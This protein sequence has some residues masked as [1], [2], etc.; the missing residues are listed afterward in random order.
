M[1]LRRLQTSRSWCADLDQLRGRAYESINHKLGPNKRCEK[2]RRSAPRDKKAGPSGAGRMKAAAEKK[3]SF[4]FLDDSIGG[5]ATSFFFTNFPEHWSESMLWENFKLLEGL[6]EKFHL[7]ANVAKYGRRAS[8]KKVVAAAPRRLLKSV[9]VVEGPSSSVYSDE[10]AGRADLV[11]PK[12]AKLPPELPSKETSEENSIQVVT[13]LDSKE[14]MNRVLLGEV[15]SFDL[16]RNIHEFKKAEGIA[17]V[18]LRYIGGLYIMI[19]FNSPFATKEYLLRSKACWSSWFKCLHPWS[20]DFHVGKRLASLSVIGLPP[21]AWCSGVISKVAMI[22]GE[23]FVQVVVDNHKFKVMVVENMAESENLV[24]WVNYVDRHSE[25]DAMS[26]MEE[27][28]DSLCGENFEDL[29]VG[30]GEFPARS[31]VH[32]NGPPKRLPSDPVKPSSCDKDDSYLE[33]QDAPSDFEGIFILDGKDIE[34]VE[35]SACFWEK[36]DNRNRKE[37]RDLKMKKLHSPCKCRRKVKRNSEGCKH[38][39]LAGD[40]KTGTFIGSRMEDRSSD[41]EQMIKRRGRYDSTSSSLIL[42]QKIIE[43]MEVTNQVGAAIGFELDDFNDQETK[44][45]RIIEFDANALWGTNQKGWIAS[46]SVGISGRLLSVWDTE[47][48]EI[49]S[50]EATRYL[51]ITLGTWK[52]NKQEI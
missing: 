18:T 11:I 34:D 15:L 25:K 44:S 45:N 37:R 43:E 42:R 51:L 4:P 1:T 2:T 28:D 13:S 39:H 47:A 7:K 16:L 30:E 3:G 17:D 22:W 5:K 19:E 40:T 9:I 31:P 8:E 26:E 6:W 35:V 49:T 24:S 38:S 29:F 33:S 32:S 48:I 50:T 21:Q 23:V 20:P 14:R 36:K 27:G 52:C 12:V 10:G 41:L 46:P